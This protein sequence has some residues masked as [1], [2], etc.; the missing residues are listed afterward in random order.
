MRLS[1]H[2]ASFLYTETASCPMHG[3]GITDIQGNVTYED[4]FNFLAGRIH[5]VPRFRQRLVFVPGNIAHPKWVDDPGFDLTDH[6]KRFEVPEGTTLEHI[7][8]AVL[9]LGEPLLD[10]NKP[11]WLTYVIENV[12]GHSLLVNMAHHAMV[13]G[14]SGVAIGMVLTDFEPNPPPVPPPTE[15]WNPAPLPTPPEL[16]LEALRENGAKAMKNVTSPPAFATDPSLVLRGNAIMQRF[17]TRPAMTAPWNAGLVG[18]K[19][20]IDGLDYMLE[21]FKGIKNALGGTINDVVLSAVSEAAARYM[22]D[23]REITTGQYIRIMVPVNVRQEGDTDVGNKVSAY[24]PLLPAWPMPMA[25]RYAY[26]CREMGTLKENKEAEVLDALTQSQ[27][28]TSPSAMAVTLAVGTPFDPTVWLAR[29]PLPVAPR[30]GFRPPLYGFNF[31]CTNVPGF[32]AQQYVCG[33]EVVGGAGTLMLSG[34][35]GY[36]VVCGSGNGHMGFS[37]TCDPRLMPDLE[38]MVHH[39]EAGM[40]ELADLAAV[41]LTMP[42]GATL[43]EHETHADTGFRLAAG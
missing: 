6:I 26:V 2:D 9:P 38:T 37:F 3:I 11:L 34:N 13:D 15:E 14:A 23:N 10:R 8:D 32:D 5:L 24:F 36:G 27:E 42:D 31:T 7:A 40:Q 21:H 41:D 12:E 29:F 30:I 43:H 39:V 1:S 16:F 20:R 4:Y 25:D 28:S 35:L 33:H 17:A 19:R 18:P 22:D